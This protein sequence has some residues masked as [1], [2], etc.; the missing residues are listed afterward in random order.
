MGNGSLGILPVVIGAAIAIEVLD[1]VAKPNGSQGV[2]KKKISAKNTT[3]AFSI[4]EKAHVGSDA[5]A[6]RLNVPKVFE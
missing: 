3:G 2:V 5:P 1:S 4:S 6:F